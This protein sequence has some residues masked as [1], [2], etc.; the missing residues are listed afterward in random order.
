VAARPDDEPSDSEP[1]H[2]PSDGPD[3]ELQACLP[4]REPARRHRGHGYPVGD[5]SRGVVDK[6]LPFKDRNY[7][8]RDAEALGDGSR[9]YSVRGRDDGA[10]D[11]SRAPR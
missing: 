10:E 3:D 8:A 5:Y 4:Q 9:G 6:A 1:H 11:E 7:A 2:H